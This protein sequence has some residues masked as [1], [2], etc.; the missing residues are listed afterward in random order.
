MLAQSGFFARFGSYAQV[1]VQANLRKRRYAVQR[2]TYPVKLSMPNFQ[3]RAKDHQRIDAGA[4]VI[5][6][7]ASAFGQTFEGAQR[8]R[9]Q[10][11]EATKKYKA[12]QKI[13]PTQW[14][15]DERQHLSSDFID[16]DEARIFDSAF[17]RNARGC[18]NSNGSDH[19]GDCEGKNSGVTGY[20]G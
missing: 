5:K 4:H 14:S 8:R 7:D 10:D 6:H 12:Q 3:H 1:D 11:V 16:H 2:L 19:D 9:F 13:F 20:P 15:D 17:A 18:G